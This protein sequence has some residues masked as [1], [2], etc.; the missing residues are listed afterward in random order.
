MYFLNPIGYVFE[1]EVGL[2]EPTITILTLF[3]SAE[4]FV[5]SYKFENVEELFRIQ[6]NNHVVMVLT[7]QH[8]K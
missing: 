4:N 5:N 1:K 3:K 6:E 7:S 8:G 2:N